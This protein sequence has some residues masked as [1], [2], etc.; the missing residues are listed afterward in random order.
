MVIFSQT[1]LSWIRIRIKR[2][3]GS[4]SALRK[5]S[6]SRSAKNEFG[7]TALVPKE[8]ANDSLCLRTADPTP[9]KFNSMDP[10]VAGAWA[11][12]SGVTIFCKV[13]FFNSVF[14]GWYEQAGL[15]SA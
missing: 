13:F 5:T 12:G 8:C 1:C 10:Q 6:G 14:L 9:C 15:G 3:P 2:A 4:G 7:S 11:K